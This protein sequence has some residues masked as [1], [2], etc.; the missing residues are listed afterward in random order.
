METGMIMLSIS[1]IQLLQVLFS[2]SP[3]LITIC[4][5][6]MKINCTFFFCSVADVTTIGVSLV[7]M[8]YV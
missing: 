6:G 4:N 3:I 8:V 5:C 1:V 7:L 2:S